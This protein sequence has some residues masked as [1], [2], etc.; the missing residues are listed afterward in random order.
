MLGG[1]RFGTGATIDGF[2]L[3]Q[4]NSSSDETITIDNLVITS[5]TAIPEPGSFA[6]IGLLAGGF[7]LRRRM[8]KSV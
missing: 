8:K 1:V 5:V 6:A 4:S 3:R 7:V 2:A